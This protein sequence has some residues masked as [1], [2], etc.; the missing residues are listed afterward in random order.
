MV[1]KQTKLWK[2]LSH[3]Y[4]NYKTIKAKKKA[5]IPYKYIEKLGRYDFRSVYKKLKVEPK[6]LNIG[7]SNACN[8]RC[9]YCPRHGEK[10]TLNSERK[11]IMSWDVV[12]AIAEQSKMMPT[13]DTIMAIGIGEIFTNREWYE[14]IEHI[15]NNS[16]IRNVTIYSNCMLLTKDNIEKLRLMSKKAKIHLI[17]SIDGISPQNTE[18]WRKGSKYEIIKENLL[19]THA[20]LSDTFSVTICC[21]NVLPPPK[22][23]EYTWESTQAFLHTAGEYLRNDFPW[24]EV[25]LYPC[26]PYVEIPGTRALSLT[27]PSKIIC[28]NIF[29]T[30]FINATGD[31]ADCRCTV[32]FDSIGNVLK[33]SMRKIFYETHSLQVTRKILRKGKYPPLCEKCE[34]RPCMNQHRML[35]IENDI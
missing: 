32:D 19:Q 18:Y 4:W 33:D 9:Q 6:V 30:I 34:Q 25:A 28:T 2:F 35:V 23:T 7:L 27:N 5:G 22:N 13:L 1:L 31:I 29:D 16:I 26:Y 12:N 10:S 14:M 8:L 21:V 24:A 15:L 11:K 20:I 3:R 17:A